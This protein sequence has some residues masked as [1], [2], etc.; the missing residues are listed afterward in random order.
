MTQLEGN[1]RSPLVC[2]ENT[3]SIVPPFFFFLLR[4]D[5]RGRRWHALNPASVLHCERLLRDLL[6]FGAPVLGGGLA[7]PHPARRRFPIVQIQASNTRHRAKSHA[8]LK[9]RELIQA[10]R[11]FLCSP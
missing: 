2:W 8:A 5:S 10:R 4:R 3:R 11:V 1:C 9:T 6:G 7:L